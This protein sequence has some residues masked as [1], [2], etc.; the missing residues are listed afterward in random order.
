MLVHTPNEGDHAFDFR[1]TAPAAAHQE[2]FNSS[3]NDSKLGGRAVAVPGEISGFAMAHARFGRLPW[4]SL[5]APNIRLARE[6]FTVSRKLSATISKFKDILSRSPAMRATYFRPD[7]TPKQPGDT[8][9]RPELASTLE[10]IAADPKRDEVFYQGAIADHLVRTV[11]EAGGILSKHDLAAYKANYSPALQST[12]RGYKVLTT[13]APSA[14]PVL[15]EAL[16]ILS[17][18]DLQAMSP[19]DRTQLLVETLKF[20]YASRMRLGDPA[21]EPE[22][23]HELQRMLDPQSAAQI[24]HKI[25]L[26]HTHEPEYY[27]GILEKV[28]D[29]GTT[30]VSVMDSEGMGVSST[31]TVNL[32]FGSKLMDPAT[33]IIL[34]NEMDDFSIPGHQNQFSLPPSPS[35]YIKP[36]KRPMSSSTPVILLR[37]GRIQMIAGGTGGSRI[38]S[39]TLLALVQMVDLG[40]SA[41][42][43]VNAPRFHHQLIPNYLITENEV[44]EDIVKAMSARGHDVHV[45]AKGFYF[46]SVQ[47][48]KR[49][50]FKGTLIAAADGRKGGGTDGY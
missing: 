29:R 3:P 26:K 4:A 50:P 15:I 14:G 43:A 10:L 34:N 12:Y 47:A 39:S 40:V 17:H 16:N 32:E 13:D 38:I 20:A 44:P 49:D 33:G 5:F 31:C 45:L 22:M 11:Q 25:D 8:I 21:F 41:V 28:H 19:A 9:T 27:S 36:G 37:N 30:H 7:G 42:E 23:I 2:M 1:E 48:I 6:G 24:K 35:N 18:F 46:S